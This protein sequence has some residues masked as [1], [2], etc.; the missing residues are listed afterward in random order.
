MSSLT[1][2]CLPLLI[3]NETRRDQLWF[4]ELG[5]LNSLDAK[6]H[7][8]A[9]SEFEHF[10]CAYSVRCEAGFAILRFSKYSV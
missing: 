9:G 5:Y 1:F 3:A 6:H 10:V 2:Q 7:L 4:Y 8:S